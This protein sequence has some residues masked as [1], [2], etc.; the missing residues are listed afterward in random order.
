MR[1]GLANKLPRDAL[2][3]VGQK[4]LRQIKHIPGQSVTY[5]Q[6][7]KVGSTSITLTLWR[8]HDPEHTPENPHAA[9]KEAPFLRQNELTAENIKSLTDSTFFSVVRNPYARF[10]SAYLNKIAS[11]GKPWQ[12]ISESFGMSPDTIP[13]LSELIEVMMGID[14]STIDH[15]FKPQHM[16]LLYGFAPID[17]VGHM[18]KMEDVSEFL[19]ERGFPLEYFKRSTTGATSLISDNISKD[20]ARALMKYYERDFH[21]YGYSEDRSVVSPIAA[22]GSQPGDKAFLTKTLTDRIQ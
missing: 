21:I 20:D 5:I 4:P 2:R 18:E 12:R 13:S 16:N 9:R 3:D 22:P 6:N 14:P 10:L 15:H 17:F 1:A 19:S 8:R 11:R 7:P